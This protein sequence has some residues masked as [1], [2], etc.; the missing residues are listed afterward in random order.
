MEFSKF[1]EKFTSESGILKLMEVEDLIPGVKYFW[2]VNY[3]EGYGY[4][5]STRLCKVDDLDTF[6][7]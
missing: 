1:T 3:G 7:G 6:E 2:D 4:G 5:D